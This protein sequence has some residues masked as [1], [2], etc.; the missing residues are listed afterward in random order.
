M[1]Q[2]I[3]GSCLTLNLTMKKFLY[4][5]N[6]EPPNTEWLKL[7]ILYLDKF[8]SIVPYGRQH[9]ISDDYRRLSNESDLVEMYSPHPD[10][11]ERASLK[12]IEEVQKYLEQPYRRSF[13]F[14][15]INLNRD[16]RDRNNWSYQIFSEKF[17]YQFGEYCQDQGIGERNGEGLILP[18]ELAFLFMSHLAKEISH[19]RDGAIITDNIEFDNY[20][21]F[22]RIHDTRIRTRLKFIKGI[23]NLLVPANIS[24]IPIDRLIQFRNRNRDLISS[25]NNQIDNIEDSIG[26][27]ITERGFV[28]SFNNVYSEL[29]REIIM[30]GIGLASIPLA[31]YVLINNPSALSAEYSKEILGALGIAMGGTYA[32][33]QAFFNTREERSCKKYLANI[34]RLR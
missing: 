15:R 7:S 21:N 2:S 11:G 28:N 22:S 5:P 9:L 25:F 16:W 13:L 33:K 19:E 34:E 4:Y 14:N 23:V 8:E 6:L 18:K 32:V 24:E 29:T 3:P 20:S 30:T 26:K 12:A 1:G 10:Q 17:S 27:G 31:S